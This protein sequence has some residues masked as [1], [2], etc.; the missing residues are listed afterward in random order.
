VFADLFL[1]DAYSRR[2]LEGAYVVLP[3]RMATN[4]SA[5]LWRK[6]RATD[7]FN[8]HNG[9]PREHRFKTNRS[10]RAA[11]SRPQMRVVARPRE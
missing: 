2:K 8:W 9:V 4:G 3:N 1:A 6:R 11:R 10:E 5:G 7:H